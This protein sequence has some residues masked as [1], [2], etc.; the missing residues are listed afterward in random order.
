MVGDEPGP[1]NDNSVRWPVVGTSV[2]PSDPRTFRPLL[3]NAAGSSLPPGA[4]FM[5]TPALPAG[6][7]TFFVALVRPGA[8]A[9]GVVRAD[10]VLAVSTAAAVF[11]P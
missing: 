3:R 8:F 2:A 11:A 6:P 1:K 5:W 9:A 4:S 10:D 7:Y